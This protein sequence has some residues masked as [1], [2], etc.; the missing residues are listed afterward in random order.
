MWNYINFFVRQRS[1][2][3]KNCNKHWLGRVRLLSEF[4]TIAHGVHTADVVHI[5]CCWRQVSWKRSKAPT[6]GGQTTKAAHR[7]RRGVCGGHR[8][9]LSIKHTKS[10][11]SSELQWER[12]NH[13]ARVITH[14]V[15]AFS[16]SLLL[17]WKHTQFKS[18]LLPVCF[19]LLIHPSSL[20]GIFD[21]QLVRP[22][23]LLLTFTTRL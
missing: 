1:S 23:P 7:A 18:Q 3:R 5:S 2:L 8:E 12:I 21:S 22:S 6:T 16:L 19:S 17:D 14:L 13:W 4:L 15:T 10:T 9:I 11:G 20:P